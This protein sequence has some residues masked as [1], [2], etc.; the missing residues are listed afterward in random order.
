MSWDY[1]VF[2]QMNNLVGHYVWLDTLG[3]FFAEYFGYVL[4]GSLAIFLMANTKK[5][6]PM[7][8]QAFAAAVIARF[9]IT[10][11]IRWLWVRPRPFVENDVNLLIDEIN[12]ASFPSGHAAFYF[13]LATIIFLYNKKL[14]AV[15]LGAAAII[16]LARVFVGVHWPSDILAGAVIGGLAGWI[17]F[18]GVRRTKPGL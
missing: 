1:A 4:V 17:I 6:W 9:G 12:H 2:Q 16:S 5:Y 8:W 15:F 13:G 18:R 3:I 14:G 10:E 11:I 7:V